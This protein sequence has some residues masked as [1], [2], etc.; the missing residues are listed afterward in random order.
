MYLK[1]LIFSVFLLT[2]TLA[3]GNPVDLKEPFG[4]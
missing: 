1:A 4:D 3:T 2:T